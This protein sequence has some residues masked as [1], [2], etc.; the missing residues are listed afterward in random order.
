M[1]PRHLGTVNIE[2]TYYDV[3]ENIR[4]GYLQKTNTLQQKRRMQQVAPG[5]P[6]P[7]GRQVNLFSNHKT[8]TERPIRH[9][10]TK[11][12][13]KLASETMDMC[14]S[15]LTGKAAKKSLRQ[16]K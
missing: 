6:N 1:W 8:Q 3:A 4:V 14:F 5:H 11:A 10:W 9:N 15:M 2:A 16:W 12:M 7:S 13:P